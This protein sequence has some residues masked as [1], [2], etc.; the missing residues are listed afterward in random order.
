MVKSLD[1][2]AAYLQVDEIERIAYLKPPKE[3]KSMEMK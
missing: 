3:A 2:R 1:M